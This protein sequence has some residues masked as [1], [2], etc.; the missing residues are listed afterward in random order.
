MVLLFYFQYLDGFI[1]F[2]CDFKWLVLGYWLHP[3]LVNVFHKGKLSFEH[4]YSKTSIDESDISSLLLNVLTL[5]IWSA[6]CVSHLNKVAVAFPLLGF[7]II[8]HI[9][10]A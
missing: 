8:C 7:R 3:F 2:L 9:S 4:R 10:P 5:L 1:D 6:V